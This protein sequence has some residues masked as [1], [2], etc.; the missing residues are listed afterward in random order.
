MF[1]LDMALAV[2]ILYN[3]SNSTSHFEDV[4]IR[5]AEYE[6]IVT[7]PHSATKENFAHLNTIGVRETFRNYCLSK[8]LSDRRIQCYVFYDEVT[9]ARE[10]LENLKDAPLLEDSMQYPC[11]ENIRTLLS[12]NR[13]YHDFLIV[14]KEG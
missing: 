2:A 6:K 9:T 5:H 12:F 14:C 4:I 8:Q 3:E 10:N 7:I 1:P 11:V 13:K